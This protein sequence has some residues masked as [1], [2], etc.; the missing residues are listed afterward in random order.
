[1]VWVSPNFWGGRTSGRR[2]TGTFSG[3]G[4]GDSSVLLLCRLEHTSH[5]TDERRKG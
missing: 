5:W 1:M 3:G 2:S 4:P